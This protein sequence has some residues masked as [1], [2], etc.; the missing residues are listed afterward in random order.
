M[1]SLLLNLDRTIHKFGMRM[2]PNTVLSDTII[3]NYVN[4]FS[5]NWQLKLQM[6][7][8]E[9]HVFCSCKLECLLGKHVKK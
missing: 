1:W 8:V 7:P 2:R 6:R 5:L 4:V 9:K 3:S